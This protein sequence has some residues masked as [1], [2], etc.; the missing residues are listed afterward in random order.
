[1]WEIHIVETVVG[2]PHEVIVHAE[3]LIGL[4]RQQQVA[5]IA[6]LQVRV[7]FLALDTGADL[8]PVAELFAEVDAVLVGVQPVLRDLGLIQRGVAFPGGLALIAEQRHVAGGDLGVRID[9]PAGKL[10]ERQKQLGRHQRGLPDLQIPHELTARPRDFRHDEAH[11]GVISRGALEI[12]LQAEP[13]AH[14]VRPYRIPPRVELQPVVIVFL[15][16]LVVERVEAAF[17]VE[18]RHPARQ[19]IRVE[20]LA[21]EIVEQ[22]VESLRVVLRARVHLHE[23][24]ARRSHLARIFA[25]PFI[26]RRF[27]R[28]HGK[29]REARHRSARG[30]FTHRDDTLDVAEIERRRVT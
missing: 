9:E 10:R 13:E 3:I 20:W 25:A 6:N 19:R 2:E 18:R 28:S 7:T 4:A 29:R 24:D 30:A 16:D 12:L 21:G 22:A 26:T 15:H 23:I 14:V 8:T 17:A 11:R 1:M 5:R 27:L